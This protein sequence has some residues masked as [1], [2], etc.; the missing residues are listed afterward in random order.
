M[1]IAIMLRKVGHTTV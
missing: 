1:Q